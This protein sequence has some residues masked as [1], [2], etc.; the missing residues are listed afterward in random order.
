MNKIRTSGMVLFWVLFCFSPKLLADAPA[1]LSLKNILADGDTIAFSGNEIEIPWHYRN[2][3]VEFEVLPQDSPDY[4]ISCSAAGSRTFQ[5]E[6]SDRYL[7]FPDL[8][9]GSK[10]HI[11]LTLRGLI[12]N[13]VTSPASNLMFSFRIQKRPPPIIKLREIIV[14]E[15]S[16]GRA[17]DL[18]LPHGLHD[19]QL[20]FDIE[21]ADS[22]LTGLFFTAVGPDGHWEQTVSGPEINFTASQPGDYR[23]I[24]TLRDANESTAASGGSGRSMIRIHLRIKDTFFKEHTQLVTIFGILLYFL[25]NFIFAWLIARDGHKTYRETRYWVIFALFSS[26]F[27]Y[28]AYKIYATSS[29]VN[30]PECNELI[31]PDFKFCPF[32]QTQLKDNCPQCGAVVQTWMHYCAACGAELSTKAEAEK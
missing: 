16:F 4:V 8:T 15:E 30:C 6:I 21:P 12:Q 20:K 26:I 23:L 24:V 27:G 9:P 13:K 32:C 14:D 7:E 5:G 1:Y 10:I 19:L 28:L 25:F 29:Q 17:T 22:P 31:S 18:V 11:K 2:I 3:R